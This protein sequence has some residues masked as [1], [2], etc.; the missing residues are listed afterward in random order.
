MACGFQLLAL[1][2]PFEL[3]RELAGQIGAE[4]YEMQKGGH[5]LDRDGFTKFDLVYEILEKMMKLTD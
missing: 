5:F 4:F 1:A 3:S 2:V